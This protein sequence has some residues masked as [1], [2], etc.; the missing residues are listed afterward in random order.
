M[1]SKQTRPA[2]EPENEDAMR[3]AW[4]ARS[5]GLLDARIGLAETIQALTDELQGRRSE[6]QL[7]AA[8]RDAAMAES[9][10]LKARAAHAEQQIHAQQQR[11]AALAGELERA[12]ADLGALRGSKVVRYTAPIRRLAYRVRAR[13]L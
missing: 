5:R 3:R 10:G 1:T 11:L 4:E 12:L 6:A 13:R 9:Q 7:A 8:Q 2:P